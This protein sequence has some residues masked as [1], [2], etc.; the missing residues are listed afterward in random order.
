VGGMSTGEPL[1]YLSSLFY[2]GGGGEVGKG[3]EEISIGNY[4]LSKTARKVLLLSVAMW[5]VV[6][7]LSQFIPHDIRPTINVT[8]LADC[9]RY[10]FLTLPHQHMTPFQNIYLD[11][12]MAIPYSLHLAW[13]I[14]F[15]LYSLIYS[16]RL[17]LPFLN[18]FGVISLLTVITELIFPTAPP[19][20]LEKYGAEPASYGLIGDPGGL[21]RVDNFFEVQVYNGT[22]SQSPLVFGAFPS[23]HVGWPTLLGLFLWFNVCQRHSH[24]AAVVLYLFWMCIAVVY[25][26]HHYVIDVIGGMVYAWVTYY[27]LGPHWDCK[28]V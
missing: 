2:Y 4:S 26:H 13:P 8:V 9:D 18:C 22:F 24:K 10:L 3:V 23:L 19:W 20:Y 15:S 16:R 5:Y 27:L 12:I 14:V 1:A 25:L 6:W 7:A 21:G 28:R 17:L 11:V